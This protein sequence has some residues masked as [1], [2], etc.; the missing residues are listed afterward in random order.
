MGYFSGSIP[1]TFE[2]KLR[3]H[4]QRFAKV[5]TTAV[6][7]MKMKFV[8]VSVTMTSELLQQQNDTITYFTC[9]PISRHWSSQEF[10]R[11]IV[12]SMLVK[13]KQRKR[14]RDILGW[15]V[16]GKEYGKKWRILMF[17]RYLK[18]TKR[19]WNTT[20][21]HDSSLHLFKKECE[22]LWV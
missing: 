15:S 13:F 19:F 9:S 1:P 12:A 2:Q 21:P 22:R 18:K 7:Y 17:G 6:L 4:Y 10:F 11:P 3:H 20:L 16:Y 8:M 14:Y 5:T